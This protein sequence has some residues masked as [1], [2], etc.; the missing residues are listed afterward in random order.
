[1]EKLK[2]TL[3]NIQ[4]VKKNLLV[5]AQKHLDTLTKPQGSLGRI[6]DLACRIIAIRDANTAGLS[7]KTIFTFA[8]DHGVTEEGISAFPKEVTAQMVANFL[9]GGAAINVL[10]KH[11]G[12][13]VVVADLGVAVNLDPRP[14]LII[15]KINYGTKNMA[16][17][18]AMTRKECIRAIETGI[19]LLSAEY[20]KGLDIAG[21]GEMGIG[22]TTSASAITAAFL[23]KPASSVTGRG[24]G[25][26]DES[27]R[28]K[29]RTVRQSIAVNRPSADDPLDVLTKVGGFEIAGLTG[30]I[31]G[32]AAKKIPV[33]IDGFISGA[34]AL[35]AYQLA[36]AAGDYMIASHCSAEQGHRLIL[37]H[38]KQKPLL[39]LGLR[40]GE[41]T[42]AALSM[43]I[44][45]A[46]LK[47]Y[48]DMATF[49]GAGVSEKNP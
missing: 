13:R 17:G 29:I 27:L 2:S 31:L 35:C 9:D 6:E 20:E 14:G 25:I 38:M 43:L 26:N 7:R 41:G 37:D 45:D 34:A 48:N 3:Y 46:A 4:G 28:R 24:T 1:M 47:I 5:T 18:P 36:P 30:V 11:A 40:L 10:A 15:E 22:N 32:A 23:K 21:T 19:N 44:V 16:R 49:S 12:A 39:D 42:G 33:V 8:A